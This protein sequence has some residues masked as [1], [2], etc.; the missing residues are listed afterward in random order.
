M[1]DP[2]AAGRCAMVER[3]DFPWGE[4]SQNLGE[5]L[6]LLFFPSYFSENNLFYFFY[7]MTFLFRREIRCGGSK[8]TFFG[9]DLGK[10]HSTKPV[11]M[12][13]R[14][15]QFWLFGYRISVRRWVFP[16]VYSLSSHLLL[17]EP[18]SMGA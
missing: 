11:R 8:T 5:Q 6:V 1:A 12:A 14:V 3:G 7:S 16:K 2:A 9:G 17:V 4:I 15:H 10:E 13:G 18:K